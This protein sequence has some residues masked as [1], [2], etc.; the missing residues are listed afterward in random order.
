MDNII[1]NF[2]LNNY[3]Y[4]EEKA[5]KDLVSLEKHKE[6]YDEFLRGINGVDFEFPKEHAVEICGYTAEILNKTTFLSVLGA[7]NYLVFLKEDEKRALDYLN[8]GLPI[9]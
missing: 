3:N 6:I 1:K 5:E 9:R 7:Y 8:K 2:I 4:T